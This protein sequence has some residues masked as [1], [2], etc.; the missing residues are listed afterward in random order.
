MEVVWCEVVMGFLLGLIQGFFASLSSFA[1]TGWHAARPRDRV[2]RHARRVG[3]C[4]LV[5]RAGVTANPVQC[6]TVE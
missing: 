1:V 6:G 2:G 3:L 5:T 4:P